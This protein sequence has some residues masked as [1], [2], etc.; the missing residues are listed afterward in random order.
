MVKRYEHGDPE[1]RFSLK[2]GATIGLVVVI[3]VHVVVYA[4]IATVCAKPCETDTVSGTNWFF[5][6]IHRTEKDGG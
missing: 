3:A 4:A 5:C 1:P 6:P 2:D